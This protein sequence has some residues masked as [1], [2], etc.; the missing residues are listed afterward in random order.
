[1][2]EYTSQNY[3]LSTKDSLNLLMRNPLFSQIVTLCLNVANTHGTINNEDV[4]ASFSELIEKEENMRKRKEI[5]EEHYKHYK[6]GYNNAKKMYRTIF[7][8]GSDCTGT[9]VES[10]EDKIF[11]YYS[12]DEATI[13]NRFDNFIEFRQKNVASTTVKIDIR[14]YQKYISKSKIAD[15]PLDKITVNN[16][17][18]FIDFCKTIKPDMTKKYW[19]NQIKNTLNQFFDYINGDGHSFRNPFKD[20]VITGKHYFSEP[21][22]VK[23]SDQ[24]YSKSEAEAVRALAMVDG[25]EHNN[26]RALGILLDF[27]NGI[28]D[29]ELMG[30]KWKDIIIDDA[31]DEAIQISRQIV[32]ETDK[33]G[34]SL[35]HKET[36]PKS[37]AG[38][39]IIKNS[40]LSKKILNQVKKINQKKGYPTGP[41]D[42]IFMRK[43]KGKLTFCTQRSFYPKLSNYCKLSG[44]SVVKS[45]HDIRRTVIT[46]MYHKI[47]KSDNKDANLKALQKFA[48]HSTLQQTLDYVKADKNDFSLPTDII[49]TLYD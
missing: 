37:K 34:K 13:N 25:F 15:M 3:L 12:K 35:G 30:L 16:A 8:D 9:T 44:M 10:L 43:Y 21:Q 2:T 27:E 49:D 48:G 17:Y 4:V 19:D 39:R 41:D 45:M 26:T 28:R 31:G 29:A 5:I 14:T 38:N 1:M 33:N 24:V 20:V 46:R 22:M 47:I 7:P 32:E 36:P 23:E 11:R 18:D 6:Q 42:Y 40:A